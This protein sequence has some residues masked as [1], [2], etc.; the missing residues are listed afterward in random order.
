MFVSVSDN[1]SVDSHP[2]F[3][4]E[5]CYLSIKFVNDVVVLIE[6]TLKGSGVAQVGWTR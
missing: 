5:L 3:L 4:Q 6:L 1:D 2:L